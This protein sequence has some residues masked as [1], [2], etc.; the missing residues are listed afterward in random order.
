MLKQ[1]NFTMN[2]GCSYYMFFDDEYMTEQQAL[3]ECEFVGHGAGYDHSLYPYYLIVP[4][5][6]ES[7]LKT[8]GKF[9][10]EKQEESLE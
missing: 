6:K 3:V 10:R 9:C 8:I 7:I 4:E 5:G 2:N 1:I